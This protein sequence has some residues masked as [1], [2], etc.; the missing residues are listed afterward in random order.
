MQQSF[1]TL[2]LTALMASQLVSAQTTKVYK[3]VDENGVTHF[4]AEPPEQREQATLIEVDDSAPELSVEESKPLLEST[5]LQAQAAPP[6]NSAIETENRRRQCEHGRRVK[7]QIEPL[8]RVF[9]EVD[10]ERVQMTDD[11][12]IRLLDEAQQNIETYCA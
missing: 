11:E 7:A 8:P 9:H 1:F 5:N 6:D 4:S 10:G 3:W 2:I 12:R